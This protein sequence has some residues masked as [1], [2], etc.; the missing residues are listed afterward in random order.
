M[1]RRLW[2]ARLESDLSRQ[3]EPDHG[4][5]APGSSELLDEDA[6]RS[7]APETGMAAGP[8]DRVPAN[9]TGTDPRECGLAADEEPRR[10]RHTRRIEWRSSSRRAIT[11]PANTHS[12]NLPLHPLPGTKGHQGTQARHAIQR[13]PALALHR[14]NR[15]GAERGNRRPRDRSEP[16]E[17][18]WLPPAP[19]APIGLTHLPSSEPVLLARQ[20]H[21]ELPRSCAGTS[22][23][24]DPRPPARCIGAKVSGRKVTGRP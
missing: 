14:A 15:S 24:T 20:A 1:Y 7:P 19:Q 5:C 17:A 21:E 13:P 11:G 18:E 8:S 23:R 12:R 3:P 9:R 10:S 4:G 6:D 16:S 22:R 2:Q